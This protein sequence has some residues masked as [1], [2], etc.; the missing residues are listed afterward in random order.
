MDSSADE[1]NLVLYILRMTGLKLKSRL[2]N[3]ELLQQK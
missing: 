1:N 2:K 3:I